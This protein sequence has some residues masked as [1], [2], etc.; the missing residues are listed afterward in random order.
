VNV[1]IMQHAPTM[2]VCSASSRRAFHATVAFL[3]V[4]PRIGITYDNGRAAE[5]ELQ[6][7]SNPAEALPPANPRQAMEIA[8]WQME[9][10]AA[11]HYRQSPLS[12]NPAQ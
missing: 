11:V 5:E 6:T 1:V 8:R 7:A 12:T 4:S 9:L 2:T 3:A 10:L